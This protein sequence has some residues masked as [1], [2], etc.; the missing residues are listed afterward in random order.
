MSM[1]EGKART[2]KGQAFTYLIA[3]AVIVT[4]AAA[5]YFTTRPREAEAV[6]P[7]IGEYEG[8]AIVGDMPGVDREAM[9]AMMQENIDASAIPFSIN[10]APGVVGNVMNLFFEN[11]QGSGKDLT[12][13]LA[14][15]E[16]GDTLYESKL[17]PEG[18]YLE[19]VEI[20]KDYESGVYEVTATITAFD[21]QTHGEIG[22]TT[23]GLVVD[24]LKR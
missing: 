6:T 21:P 19:N 11:P 9:L 3:A 20:A 24:V 23:A 5:V 10:A 18:S 16:T 14:D 8:G 15:D 7:P 12:I 13:L 1:Q 4:L 22:V 2:A 17:V